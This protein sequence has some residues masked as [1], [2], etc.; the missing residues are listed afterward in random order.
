MYLLV[1]GKEV[2]YLQE[3]V[4]SSIEKRNIDLIFNLWHEK[5]FSLDSFQLTWKDIEQFSL[6]E[7]SILPCFKD[8]PSPV[9]LEIK[10]KNDPIRSG[11]CPI[12]TKFCDSKRYFVTIRENIILPIDVY[13]CYDDA[14]VFVS[15]LQ[16]NCNSKKSFHFIFSARRN[17]NFDKEKNIVCIDNVCNKIF[18]NILP[19]TFLDNAIEIFVE[20]DENAKE[21]KVYKI[22]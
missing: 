20:Y 12:D 4:Y 9:F 15:Y 1:I 5:C 22:N 13:L 7:C 14:S 10:Y 21:Y 11:I 8:D 16:K 17:I 6:Y 3:E 2:L 19:N 18:C